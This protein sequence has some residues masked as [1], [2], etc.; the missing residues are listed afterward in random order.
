MGR[1][2]FW[3]GEPGNSNYEYFFDWASLPNL[4]HN[5]KDVRD[6]FIKAA[7]YWVQEYDIDGYRCDVAWGVEERN[8]DFWQEWRTALKNIK[9]EVF[10]EA[11]ASSISR[12]LLSAKI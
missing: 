8:S 11:E 6:Y 4:N 5:N 3:E 2:L 10:L 12:S 1:F 9:P 7:K